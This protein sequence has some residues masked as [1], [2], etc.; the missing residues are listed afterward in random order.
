MKFSLLTLV[1][2]SN[3]SL[4]SC[5]ASLSVD[6]D[7]ELSHFCGL[8]DGYWFA[9]FEAKL[10]WIPV[11]FPLAGGISQNRLTAELAALQ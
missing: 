5:T 2:S 7:K 9:I 10:G 1:K 4:I 8:A 6:F 3:D 11:C